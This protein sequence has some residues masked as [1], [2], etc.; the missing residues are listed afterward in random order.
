MSLKTVHICKMFFANLAS[1]KKEKIVSLI[2]IF[3][4]GQT[5]IAECAFKAI[6]VG[7][8]IEMMNVYGK[9]Y[10][11]CLDIALAYNDLLRYF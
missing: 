6:K 1:L 2:E 8:K 7:F 9:N 3:A 4:L 11:I 10:D 5:N